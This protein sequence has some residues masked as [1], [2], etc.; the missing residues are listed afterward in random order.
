LTE[1]R[2]GEEHKLTERAR[3]IGLNEAVFREVNERI[4]GLAGRFGLTT[5][6][7]DLV[8]ECGDATCAERIV[9]TLGDYERIRADP[10]L[11]AVVPG[12]EAEDVE[13]VVEESKGYAVIRKHEGGES[14]LA[15]ATDP[16][17]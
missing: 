5:Q 12:H 13:A 8:C 9:M 10:A 6:P 11:F 3:R 15:R 7:L 1:H 2:D 4:R 17:S 16:R 14:E